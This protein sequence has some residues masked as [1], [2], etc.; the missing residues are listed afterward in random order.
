MFSFDFFTYL[1]KKSLREK[2]HEN[3]Y[4]S[5]NK[6]NTETTTKYFKSTKIYRD[7]F[8]INEMCLFFIPILNK[9]QNTLNNFQ[10]KKNELRSEIF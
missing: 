6:G 5:I 7:I 3:P 2:E 4:R 1:Q 8:L 10:R 9:K